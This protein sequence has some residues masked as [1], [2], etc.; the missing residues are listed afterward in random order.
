MEPTQCMTEN[1]DDRRLAGMAAGI[2]CLT[3]STLA[4]ANP[5]V[6]PDT[7]V[8]AQ[9]NYGKLPLNFEV[10]QGQA[11]A[12][13]KFLARGQGYSLFLTPAEAV[14]SL[15]KSQA[16][17]RISPPSTKSSVASETAGTVL[18]MQ[19]AGASPAPK[20]AGK[21]PLPGRVN[22]LIGKDP[23]RWHTQ[24]P[25]YA[26][27]AYENVYP[28][29]DLVYYG[30]QG[31]LEY[32]FVVAPG[33]D[34]H[35][36]KLAFK[37]ASH[38]E[39]S[40]AGELVL[41]TANGDI[42][43]HK[44]VIYQEVQGV[45]KPISGSYEL[46]E[47]Q[48]VGFQVAAYDADIPLVIDPVLVYSTYLG[49]SRGDTGND[50]AVD[51]RGQ[52]YVAGFTNS[53]DFPT[54]NAL[55][56]VLKGEPGDE[57]NVDAFV[58][59]L[60]ADGS[61]LVYST[62]LG[63]DE[64]ETGDGIAVDRRG[65]AIVTGYTRST[66]F[67]THNA[68]QPTPGSERAVPGVERTDRS[69]RDT[70]VAQLTADGSA[71]VYSTYLGG[72]EEE[73]VHDIAVDRQGQAIVT[74]YTR[75]T[76]YPVMNAFQPTYGGGFIDGFV[77][78]L[79]ADGRALRYSTYLGGSNDDNS[80]GVAVD[81]LGRISV[82]GS[83]SSSNF[84]TRNALQPTLR[85]DQSGGSGSDAFVTQFT[86][87]G[88]E[89]RYSTYLGGSGGDGGLSIAADLLG[90]VYVTGGTSSA[91]FPTK[92]A[93]QP[94]FGGGREG[95]AFVAKLTANGRALAYS[96]YLGGSNDDS[97]SGIAVDLRGQA[98]VAGGTQSPDFPTK[99]ALQP[100]LHGDVD[101]FV[102]QFAA[103]GRALRYSTYLGARTSGAAIAVD[104]LGRAYVAGGTGSAEFPTVNA[105][106]PTL[107]GNGD[108]FVLKIRN[109]NR[110]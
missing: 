108:A 91:D 80:W 52:A 49:G 84:P 14:L 83:T 106:Q 74:G 66:D 69:D 99:D 107:G 28:G 48:T 101:S 53:T 12:Q 23:S 16:Q 76:D 95:D 59:K 36:I 10:N 57:N 62:Y 109:D 30:N 58:A 2:V 96:T 67:P 97:G 105:L 4:S 5:D 45:R 56:P 41:H 89:L 17:A 50:I 70:F 68:F 38:I 18:R 44:P 78:Q 19:L 90:Q 47:G 94:A 71:F 40:P 85:P 73:L 20:V 3:L 39:V 77:T 46:K 27:V 11:D 35:A 15:K 24:V 42:R 61:A 86:A 104:L 8:Q 29:V 60:T 22:Y 9:A 43:M 25:T 92:N 51:Q 75:S 102:T 110:P 26:K 31:K 37:G 88:R 72:S 54:R 34:P 93:F 7:K 82:T 21:G 1:R 87:N 79:T 100:T 6:A 98:S 65:Q 81:L 55:Q 103:S 13:V 63:G 33:A 64:D 32:D